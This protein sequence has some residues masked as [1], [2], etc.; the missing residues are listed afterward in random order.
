MLVRV[1]R[2]LHCCCRRRRDVEPEAPAIGAAYPIPR[3]AQPL[4]VEDL[5]DEWVEPMTFPVRSRATHVR[6]ATIR[7][8]RDVQVQS[9]CTYTA[10]RG[11]T[12]ARFSPHNQFEGEVRIGHTYTLE[13]LR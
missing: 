7:T 11:V 2:A 1:F 9:P 8:V 6:Y 12:T 10:L 13:D 3:Y 5:G 4:L